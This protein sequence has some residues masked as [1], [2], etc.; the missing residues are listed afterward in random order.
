MV[1]IGDIDILEMER[2]IFSSSTR[3]PD[4]PA[5]NVVAIPITLLRMQNI[6]W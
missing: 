3:C 2:D 1:P 6:N 4:L 5:R